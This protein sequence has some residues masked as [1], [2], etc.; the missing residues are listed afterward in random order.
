MVQRRYLTLFIVLLI[1]FCS[2]YVAS[3]V[4]DDFGAFSVNE[5]TIPTQSYTVRGTLYTPKGING[6]VPAF[7][8]AHGLSNSKEVLSGIALELARNGYVALTIDEKGHGESDAGFDVTDPTLGLGAA[9][10]YLS[11]LPY[12]NANLIG[13]CGHSMGAGAVRAT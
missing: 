3:L 7:A 2:V 8:L 1:F 13:I 9:V 4:N 12:V 11:T 10:A 6:K 5:V